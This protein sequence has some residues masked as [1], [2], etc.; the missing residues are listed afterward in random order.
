MRMDA[1]DVAQRTPVSIQRKCA[2]CEDEEK[3]L[4]KKG[5]GSLAGAEAPS[6]VHQVLQAGGQPLDSGARSFLEPR[7]GR[8]FSGVRV[9][10]GPQAAE[11]AQE[12][13][14]RAYT[15][16]NHVVFGSGHYAPHTN[17]GRALLAH[18]LTHVVQQGSELRRQSQRHRP[19]VSHRGTLENAWA[20][21]SQFIQYV[22]RNAGSLE[23][24]RTLL[25]EKLNSPNHEENAQAVRVIR[26][27]LAGYAGHERQV[28]LQLRSAL[29]TYIQRRETEVYETTAPLRET[30][31]ALHNQLLDTY[32][33]AA[34]RDAFSQWLTQQ[35]SQGRRPRR[36]QPPRTAEE[37]DQLE[38]LLNQTRSL[39]AESLTRHATLKSDVRQALQTLLAASDGMT[40]LQEDVL[41]QMSDLIQSLV[42]E[43]RRTRLRPEELRISLNFEARYQQIIARRMQDQQEA[44]EASN[45]QRSLAFEPQE[46]T[47]RHRSGRLQALRQQEIR[48]A[49]AL[50]RIR[51]HDRSLHP[52]TASPDFRPFLAERALAGGPGHQEA[53]LSAY[54]TRRDAELGDAQTLG[55]GINSSG[56][57]NEDARAEIYRMGLLNIERGASAYS[58]EGMV[59][60]VLPHRSQMAHDRA[61]LGVSANITV[62]TYHSHG[63]GQYDI[64]ARAGAPVSV[65]MPEHIDLTLQLASAAGNGRRAVFDYVSSRV[66]SR[67][68]IGELSANGD[69]LEKLQYGFFGRRAVQVDVERHLNGT[70]MP[71]RSPDASRILAGLLFVNTMAGS[72]PSAAVAS[73]RRSI[74]EELQRE[75]IN[76][77]GVT[78]PP[79]SRLFDPVDAS[80]GGFAGSTSIHRA[81]F[82]NAINPSTG[83]N[84]TLSEAT[85]AVLRTTNRLVLTHPGIM[86]GIEN[87]LRTLRG[88]GLQSNRGGLTANVLHLYRNPDT[89][90]EIWVKVYYA[91]LY[92]FAD[93]FSAGPTARGR[94]IG[95]VGSTGNAVSPHVHMSVGVYLQNPSGS[96]QSEPSFFLEPLDF[97]Q[98]MRRAHGP[99]SSISGNAS[100]TG[101]P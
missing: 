19:P 101:N 71:N 9:H 42:S 94:P 57:I 58:L 43:R 41:N 47:R 50:R 48:E 87:L 5:D 1:A 52:L 85:S 90:Q 2:T 77:L 35:I 37:T 79:E 56:V 20:N 69:I 46:E 53:E 33:Q 36:G 75:I 22:N 63:P 16:G 64:N 88:Q 76:A 84:F 100:G 39:L 60:L 4:H 78:L 32:R 81:T 62:G 91:H 23:T 74:V 11:S 98:L 54:R 82:L 31:L 38:A 21:P 29:E 34:F 97:F 13:G 92:H 89:Q 73:Q 3:R 86:T 93:G 10:T 26:R 45:R 49:G 51:G 14:A 12:I 28:V 30:V 6:A 40:Y 24:A 68:A 72:E 61:R 70:P 15:V 27:F 55:T 7:F 95:Y 80:Q 66:L 18:E 67:S 96:P 83:R 17:R 65:E 99:H 8:D 44:R 25:L 59:N